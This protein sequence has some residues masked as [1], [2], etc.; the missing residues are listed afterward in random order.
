MRHLHQLT[1]HF[2]VFCLID[3]LIYYWDAG[4]LLQKS[5]GLKE[6][7]PWKL[8]NAADHLRVDNRVLAEDKCF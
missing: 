3:F 7:I 2:I 5:A 4:W 1:P 6:E 8:K